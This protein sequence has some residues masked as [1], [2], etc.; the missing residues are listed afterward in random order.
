MLKQK[1]TFWNSKLGQLGYDGYVQV[2]K[3]ENFDPKFYKSLISSHHWE[4]SLELVCSTKF[5]T[6][7]LLQTEHLH[8]KE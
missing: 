7:G 1:T 8:I 2:R 3:V 4:E 5:K 6:T